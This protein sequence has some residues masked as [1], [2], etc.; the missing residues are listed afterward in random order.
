MQATSGGAAARP[1]AL[2]G[3]L[4]RV[5]GDGA[6]LFLFPLV[7]MPRLVHSKRVL[8]REAA[9]AADDGHLYG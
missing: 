2:C 1:L 5:H 6:L 7:R 9:R 8:P 4:L 3:R